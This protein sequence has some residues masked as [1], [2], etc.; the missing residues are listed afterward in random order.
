LLI[1]KLWDAIASR[2]SPCR[3]PTVFIRLKAAACEDFS[4]FHVAYDQGRL[5]LFIT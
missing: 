3:T 1:S 4:S 2:T 5:T